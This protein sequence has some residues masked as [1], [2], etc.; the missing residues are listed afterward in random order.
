MK[1]LAE[2]QYVKHFQYG[3]GVVT[4]SNEDRTS[5]DFD[6]HGLKKFVTSMMV[7]EP[8]EGTPPKRHGSKRRKK[9]SGAAAGSSAAGAR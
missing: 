5:I 4:E 7:V 6:L 3:C 2:G 1:A 8:A 9:A